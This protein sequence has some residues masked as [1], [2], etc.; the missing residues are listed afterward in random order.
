[1]LQKDHP[2]M[3]SGIFSWLHRHFPHF[4]DCRPIDAAGLMKNAGFDIKET[5]ET[6]I[7]TLPVV[8]VLATA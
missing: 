5:Q 8:I 6:S 1:M 7:A 4:I 2:G 3:L